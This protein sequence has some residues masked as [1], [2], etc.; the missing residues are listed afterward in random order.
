MVVIKVVIATL[1]IFIYLFTLAYS[2]AATY[3]G[4]AILQIKIDFL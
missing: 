2:I 3:V 1:A 4:V